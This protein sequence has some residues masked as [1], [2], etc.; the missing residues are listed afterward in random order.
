VFLSSADWMDRNLL[1]RVE[2]CFPVD[3][4]D[5]RKRVLREVGYYLEDNTQAWELAADGSYRHVIPAEGEEA[6]SAQ[7]RLFQELVG[8]T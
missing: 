5:L 7:L 8:T 3:H 2:T 6:R 1:Q 4:K